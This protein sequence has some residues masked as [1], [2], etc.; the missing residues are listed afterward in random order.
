MPEKK[1]GAVRVLVRVLWY[2]LIA[3]MAAAVA[4]YICGVMSY[5]AAIEVF[6]DGE[7]VGC[8][9]SMS[10][11]RGRVRLL[12]SELSEAA[13]E[14]YSLAGRVTFGVINVREPEYL[15]YDDMD[16][17][18]AAAV[19]RDFED[20]YMLY[21]DDRMVGAYADREALEGLIGDIEDDILES[22]NDAYSDVRINN[23]I[24]IEEQ[25]CLRTS[26]MSLE[27]IDGL[28]NPIVEYD[29]EMTYEVAAFS[30]AGAPAAAVDDDTDTDNVTRITAFSAL[31]PEDDAVSD[32]AAVA[33][34]I[35]P[36]VDFGM[37]RQA[38]PESDLT[39]SYTFLR[40]ETVNEI[41]RCETIYIDDEERY[42]GDDEVVSEGSDGSRTV[43]Y[44][45]GFDA[46]GRETSRRE[47]TVTAYV[48]PVERVV[49]RGVKE[50][51]AAVP[52]G[53]FIWPCDT[54]KDISSGYGGRDLYGSY[55]FHLGIDI[56]NDEGTPIYAADGGEVVWAGF[57][58]S[59]G[60]HVRIQHDGD[61]VTLYAHMK[62][63]KVSVG[64]K[65]FQGQ[66]IGIMGH[67]G[68]AYGTHLHFE[69]RHG[70]V[71]TDPMK[72]LPET[73]AVIYW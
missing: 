17:A 50:K 7:S 23:H 42:T 35:D 1:N 72:C 13:G 55:D 40:T 51:P 67:T 28:I 65:V 12:E 61:L 41:L 58:P 33:D 68:A 45:I 30:A 44:E 71:T 38:A 31:A 25:P 36:D 37:I 32:T 34:I 43:T 18:L 24:R 2:A 64:D 46:D 22:G 20:A 66:Q 14:R 10:A 56:P 53:T 5:D 27:E 59:Y 47:K 21:V 15:T 54:S 9:S 39:L 4:V 73:D 60:N 6:V 29:A 26:L 3:V 52:T 16:E 49:I 70:T 57:T 48:P 8:V 19:G 62:E 11:V 63:L 69:V